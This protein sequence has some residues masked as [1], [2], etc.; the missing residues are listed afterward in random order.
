MRFLIDEN[1]G[2][3]VISFLRQRG[4]DV[5]SVAQQF[6]G[7]SDKKVLEKARRQKRILITADKDFGDLIFYSNQPHKGV[8]LLRTKNQFPQAKIKALDKLLKYHRR[9]IIENF[10]VVTEDKIRIR[11]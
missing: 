10:I 9:K 6:P 11:E 1:I 7:I 8:I 4:F 2:H 5:S 3:S